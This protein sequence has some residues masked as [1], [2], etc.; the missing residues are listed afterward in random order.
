MRRRHG[1]LTGVKPFFARPDVSN[2]APTSRAPPTSYSISTC[3]RAA[4]YEQTSLVVSSSSEKFFFWGGGGR[5]VRAT[6]G[7]GPSHLT[8][9]IL[10][11]QYME[12]RGVV[13]QSDLHL[14]EQKKVTIHCE[15]HFPYIVWSRS[16]IHSA[17][18]DECPCYKIDGCLWLC[19][20]RESSLHVHLSKRGPITWRDAD[21]HLA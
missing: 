20:P 9:F 4:T 7:H 18:I 19:K 1:R 13:D 11:N 16:V 12:Q 15:G 3:L 14:E 8:S 6:H 17:L 21:L 2:T 5:G 10:I